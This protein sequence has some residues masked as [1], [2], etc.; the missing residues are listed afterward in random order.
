MGHGAM[1]LHRGPSGAVEAEPRTC[2]LHRL[3][4]TVFPGCIS[5]WRHFPNPRLHQVMKATLAMW[6]E[7]IAANFLA[8]VGLMLSATADTLMASWFIPTAFGMATPIP[9]RRVRACLC[10]KSRGPVARRNGSVGNGTTSLVRDEAVDRGRRR[11]AV[12]HPGRKPR[13]QHRS[14]GNQSNGR[15]VKQRAEIHRR[16]PARTHVGSHERGSGEIGV[17]AEARETGWRE[18]LE[19]ALQWPNDS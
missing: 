13:R 10:F 9:A 3:S 18:R 5:D 17:A 19:G 12:E 16:T 15:A 6:R 1:P 8:S 4:P 11:L 14:D 2:L 7:M